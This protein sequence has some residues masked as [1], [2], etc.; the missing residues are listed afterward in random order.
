MIVKWSNYALVHQT[1]FEA[2]LTTLS[3]IIVR[4]CNLRATMVSFSD[5]SNAAQ[6]ATEA[7]NISAAM[8]RWAEDYPAGYSYSTVLLKERSDDVFSDHYHVYETVAASTTWNCYRAVHI[9]VNELIVHLLT[10]L[11]KEQP[12]LFVPSGSTVFSEINIQAANATI[13]RLSHDICSSVPPLLGFKEGQAKTTR[14]I[15]SVC[16]NLLLWPLYTAAVTDSVSE[17][18]CSWVAGR[19][20]LISDTIG[21]KQA[22]PLA[23]V[24]SKK[25]DVVEWKTRP[26]DGTDGTGAV[27]AWWPK[28]G[29]AMPKDEAAK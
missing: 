13:L 23:H 20:R 14:K 19:L 10:D 18:M 21:V 11:K 7:Y 15:K 3:A 28:A 26:K 17:L 16:G 27:L 4:Y 22:G 5:F 24:L 8:S 6:V 12:A 9:I 2:H 29:D 1:P 25:Q